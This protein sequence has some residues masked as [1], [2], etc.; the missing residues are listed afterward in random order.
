MFNSKALKEFRNKKRSKLYEWWIESK[1]VDWYYH[2]SWK[3]FGNPWFQIKRLIQWYWNVFRFD[4][5]FDGHCLFAIIEYKLKR[6]QKALE[7]GHAI[8]EDRDMKALNMAI[9]L[10]GRLKDEYENYEDPFYRRHDKK[11]GKMKTWTIPA[12][13]HPG[14]FIWKHSR[15]KAKTKKQKKFEIK[16]FMAMGKSIEA[17]KKREEKWLYDILFKYLRRWWD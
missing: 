11:W 8:Q 3:F 7:H 1:L 16:D 14:M 10:A 17:K 12:E 2:Y 15:S 9:E 13:D 6:I 4:Y 5:D